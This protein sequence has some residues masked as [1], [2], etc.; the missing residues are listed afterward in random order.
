MFPS[1]GSEAFN[2]HKLSAW[3]GS[4]ERNTV[5]PSNR[6]GRTDQVG[7]NGDARRLL[8]GHAPGG[9]RG[10]NGSKRSIRVMI[11]MVAALITIPLAGVVAG[12][13]ATT[14]GASA[15]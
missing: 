3:A 10:R 5:M 7:G 8:S 4:A 1:I 2:P 13:S 9:R 6:A 14:A 15:S 12:V 11:A